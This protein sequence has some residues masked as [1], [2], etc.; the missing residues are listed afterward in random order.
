MSSVA[1][2]KE[3]VRSFQLLSGSSNTNIANQPELT[4]VSGNNVKFII[5]GSDFSAP[6]RFIFSARQQFWSL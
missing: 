5:K 4:T 1:F 6:V 3:D 2:D